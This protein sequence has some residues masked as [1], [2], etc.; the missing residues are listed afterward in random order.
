MNID[1]LAP[2][3]RAME[4]FTAGGKLQRCRMAFLDEIP[5]PRSIL[6]VGEGHG[7][8]LPECARRFPD[9]T[10]VVVDSSRRMLAIA[11][12]K[13]SSPLVEFLHADFLDWHPPRGSFDLVVTQ[14]F[15]DCLTA[16]ELTLAAA[17]LGIA[18]APRATWLV[19]DFE[20]APAGWARLRSRWIVAI[21]YRFFRITSG[22]RAG[23]L[24]PPD[25]D[26]ET[27]GFRREDRR[28]YE[29]GLLKSE[30]WSRGMDTCGTGDPRLRNADD[31]I[32]T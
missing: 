7:R 11:T 3:Y 32:S 12:S 20:L 23:E 15:L 13:V 8:F 16:E 2:V 22:L 25:R 30:R 10:I 19:A 24:V 27:A 14:F 17:K 6:L 1:R 18:A 31:A 5:A 29:W 21:L 4:F 28:V 26:L 9:A